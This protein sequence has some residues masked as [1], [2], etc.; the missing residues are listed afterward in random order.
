MVFHE[1]LDFL[2]DTSFFEKDVCTT[3]FVLNAAGNEDNE[4]ALNGVA[5]SEPVPE[6]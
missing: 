3:S 6:S 1:N 4:S 5:L 2:E